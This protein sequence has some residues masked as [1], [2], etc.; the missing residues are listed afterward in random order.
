MLIAEEIALPR[1]PAATAMPA[2]TMARINAYSA[3][4]APDSSR[5]KDFRKLNIRYPIVAAAVHPTLSLRKTGIGDRTEMVH[6]RCTN[7]FAA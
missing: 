2:P 7:P 1:L 3:A 4:A 5:T 6:A